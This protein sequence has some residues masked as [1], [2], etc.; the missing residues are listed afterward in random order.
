MRTRTLHLLECQNLQTN[1]QANPP[2]KGKGLTM[3]PTTKKKQH[4][5]GTPMFYY[6]LNSSIRDQMNALPE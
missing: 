3:I 4:R 6:N 1:P 5:N 2:L